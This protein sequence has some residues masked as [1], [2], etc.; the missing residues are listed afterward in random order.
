[1]AMPASTIKSFA[2]SGTSVTRC[3]SQRRR[4]HERTVSPS[5][6]PPK[7]LVRLVSPVAALI[8]DAGADTVAYERLL[9]TQYFL[10]TALDS[11]QKELQYGRNAL[12]ALPL[13][14][15]YISRLVPP[16]E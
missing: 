1:M 6:R 11:A 7:P 16:W 15:R 5:R 13:R 10:Q 8:L 3:H 2:R 12:T 14:S 4:A 9:G